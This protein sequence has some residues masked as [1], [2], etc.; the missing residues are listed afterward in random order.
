MSIV[1]DSNE[2]V[3]ERHLFAHLFC[4]LQA[5]I[6]LALMLI[7]LHCEEGRV[8]TGRDYY[9]QQNEKMWITAILSNC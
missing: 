6:F 2:F 8:T 3:F 4:N 1:C 5:N 7:E 9:K